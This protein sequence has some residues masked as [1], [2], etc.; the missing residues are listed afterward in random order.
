MV[1]GVFCEQMVAVFGTPAAVQTDN[2]TEFEGEFAAYYTAVGIQCKHSCPYTS[3]S[4]GVVERLHHIVES[5]LWRC[6]VTGDFSTLPCLLVDIPLAINAT[7]GRS[8]GC[9][10]YLV[11][12]DTPAPTSPALAALPDPTRGLHGSIGQ[13]TET[14]I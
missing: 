2:G 10:P 12:F 5:M 8:I 7:Y 4:Q 3:H 13:L 9:P 14:E 1:V 11:M 6:L